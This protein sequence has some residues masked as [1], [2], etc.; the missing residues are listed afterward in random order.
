V[1]EQA[2][3]I[4]ETVLSEASRNQ[5]AKVA[6]RIL[7]NKKLGFVVPTAAQKRILLVEFARKN[8]T[9]YGKA[10]DALKLSAD[11]DLDD[12]ES[13]ARHMKDIVVCE[14]KSTSKKKLGPD[15]RGYFFGLTTAELL[16]AQNLKDRFRFIFVNTANRSHLEL[17]LG[18]L[19]A[20]AR[21]VYPTWSISF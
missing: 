2:N 17:T 16:V 21:G 18:Q 8:L 1:D 5:T 20:K 12:P 19:F 4:A 9:L 3:K 6:A 14:I 15:F 13:V 10:F 7:V 11:M